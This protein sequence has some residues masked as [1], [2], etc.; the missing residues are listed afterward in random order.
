[1]F[2]AVLC[3]RSAAELSKPGFEHEYGECLD[4]REFGA[5]L[6]GRQFLA[7]LYVDGPAKVI[8]VVTDP[9]FELRG[10]RAPLRVMAKEKPVCK[11]LGASFK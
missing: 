7:R 2:A 11:L 10:V 8:C 3:R 4:P 1:M 6:S 5:A 9:G